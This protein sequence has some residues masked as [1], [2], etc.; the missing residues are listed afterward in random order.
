MYRMTSGELIAPAIKA[1]QQQQATY[2]ALETSVAN[3]ER[4]LSALNQK[5]DAGEKMQQDLLAKL[6]QLKV[7][8][9]SLRTQ[10]GSAAE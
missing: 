7:S 1:M 3:L 10:L 6:Q 8:N 9:A 5:L 2:V 4:D